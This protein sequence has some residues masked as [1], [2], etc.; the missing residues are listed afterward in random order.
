MTR[1]EAARRK[2]LIVQAD[3]VE[4]VTDIFTESGETVALL[5]EV[6]EAQGDQRVVYHGHLDLAQ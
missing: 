3:A 6:I 4:K 2:T 1:E 5:G